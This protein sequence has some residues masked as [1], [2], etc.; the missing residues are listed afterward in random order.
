MLGSA[1]LSETKLRVCLTSVE[2]V[3]NSRPLTTV[4]EDSNDLV[5]LTPA[6]FLIGEASTDCPEAELISTSWFREVYA[7][8]KSVKEELQSRFRKEYLSQLLQRA[9][10]LKHVP[11]K[12]GDV[13]FLGSDDKKRQSW[14]LG[15]VVKVI[16]GEDGIV[17]TVRVKT[18]YGEK[19]RPV[20]RLYPTEISAVSEVTAEVKSIAK[21]VKMIQQQQDE[22][23]QCEPDK[24]VR[25]RFGR[26][27][28][29]PKL[30]QP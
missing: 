25:T 26:I 18:E 20:G 7:K 23:D 5:P 27:V 9:K 29:R 1:K 21:K 4:S 24:Q 12:V 14:P 10:T 8:K 22:T 6:M 19:V 28:N 2:R 13:V 30:F 16:P 15:L 11:I 3:V 17:R